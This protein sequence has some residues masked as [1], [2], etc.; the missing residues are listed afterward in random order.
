LTVLWCGSI[1]G[2]RRGYPEAFRRIVLD[3]A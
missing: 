1:V 2:R 3:H